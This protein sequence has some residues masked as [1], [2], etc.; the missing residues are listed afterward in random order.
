MVKR[1]DIQPSSENYPF[2]KETIKERP[3]DK[4]NLLHKI[5]M[6]AFCGVIF[7]GSAAG[8]AALVFPGIVQSMGGISKQREDVTMVSDEAES[9]KENIIQNQNDTDTKNAQKKNNTAQDET[10]TDI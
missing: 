3:T 10:Y 6:A 9:S 2:I 7:G 1:N 8:T 5:L 4:K